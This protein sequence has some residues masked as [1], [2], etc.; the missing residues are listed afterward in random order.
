[1]KHQMNQINIFI[2]DVRTIASS[3]LTRLGTTNDTELRIKI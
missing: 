1:M 2:D 3:I